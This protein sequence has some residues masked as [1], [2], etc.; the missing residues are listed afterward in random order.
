MSLPNHLRF[1]QKQ[2]REK[3]FTEHKGFVMPGIKTKQGLF[4]KATSLLSH[5]LN[6]GGKFYNPFNLSLTLFPSKNT[7]YIL[8]AH[9]GPKH[10]W[11]YI[12]YMKQKIWFWCEVSVRRTH[13]NHCKGLSSSAGSL[14]G[15]PILM[16]EECDSPWI[17][18]WIRFVFWD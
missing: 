17:Q 5:E 18:L 11:I 13:T 2:M 3:H 12:E 4:F 16:H 9:T 10:L 7:W 1:I 14:Q 8:L 15:F 6:T